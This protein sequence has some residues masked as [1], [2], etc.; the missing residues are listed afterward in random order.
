MAQ[1]FHI[2]VTGAVAYDTDPVQ[3]AKNHILAILL[4]SSGERVMRPTYG[5]GMY[6]M[7]FEND[8][9]LIEQ[10]LLIAI[11]MAMA[12]WEP[13]ITIEICK[14]LPQPNYSGIVELEVGFSVGSLPT[15]YTV[16]Y[17]ISGR[18]VEVQA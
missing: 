14:F 13:N 6:Q 2:D 1:P 3:W 7:V 4:T 10:Q 11:Q 18:G 8:N 12:M 17:A 16:S 9:P 15:V 5:V